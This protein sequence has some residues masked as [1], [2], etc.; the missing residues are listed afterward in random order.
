MP[1]RQKIILIILII[2]IIVFIIYFVIKYLN[3]PSTSG[4][5]GSQGGSTYDR[6]LKKIDQIKQAYKSPLF[7]DSR[8]L[9]LKAF[10]PLPI[11]IG[12]VGNPNPFQPL[13]SP[14]EA[15]IKSLQPTP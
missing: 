15:L 5:L 4:L 13:V 14:T 2:V 12:L 3:N 11:E 9:V 7:S 8:F 6:D 1:K 10:Y